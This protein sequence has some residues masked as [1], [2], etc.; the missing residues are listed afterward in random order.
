MSNTYYIKQINSSIAYQFT[1]AWHYSGI[2]F[3]KAQLNLGIFRQ[4]DS[5]LV[6]VQ[7]WGISAQEHVRLDRYVKEPITTK[8]YLE[9]NRFCMADSE[10]R[11]SESKAIGLGIHWIKQN[12]PHIRLLVS[13][14]GR[15]E[16]NYGY[17]YQATNWEY[18]GYFLSTGF[19]ELDGQEK[20][21]LTICSWNKKYH[22][23]M[24]IIDSLC[25]EYEDVKQYTSKQFIYIQRL[26]KHL[27]PA[28]DILP[29]PKP[30]TDAPIQTKVNI[31][32]ESNK[33]FEHHNRPDPEYYDTHE[34][35]ERL[36]T[37]RTLIRR[38]EL[39]QENKLYAMYSNSGQLEKVCNT[40]E[41]F[42]PMGY[43]PE[44]VMH[45][46]TTSKIYR[47]KFFR[48]YINENA[49]ESITF[50]YLCIID[51]Q[52]FFKQEEAGAYLGVSKQAVSAAR[53][54]GSTVIAG[55]QIQWS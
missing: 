46:I 6:G 9:L 34:E 54:R 18:L 20:H 42:R 47:N 26:D 12:W 1:C 31:Y 45:A 50:P 32:K 25:S 51:G 41:E 30:A 48:M 16:G 11:N 52:T 23:D 14:A 17:I 40:M 33:V 13:Y 19:W 27:T 15:K 22:P 37:R 49:A 29:Y 36:F 35:E 4:S 53:K 3:K 28:S 44:S 21:H 55:K 10:G 8:E 43:V 2:G 38:G 7:Q 5:R 39:E 24:T